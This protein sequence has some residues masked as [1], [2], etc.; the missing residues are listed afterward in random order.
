MNKSLFII[1][2]ME[3]GMVVHGQPTIMTSPSD[4]F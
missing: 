3:S 1:V 2:C 4:D